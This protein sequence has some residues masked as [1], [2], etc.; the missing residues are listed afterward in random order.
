MRLR[1]RSGSELRRSLAVAVA[2]VVALAV[3]PVGSSSAQTTSCDPTK[4]VLRESNINQGL[5][6]DFLVRGKKILARF[7]L[8]RASCAP[9]SQQMLI[10]SARLT[11]TGGASQA[12]LTPKDSFGTRGAPVY[13]YDALYG[14]AGELLAPDATSHPTFV[15]D[16]SRVEA[17]ATS[18][19]SLNLGLTVGY[20]I[21]GGTPVETTFPPVSRMVSPASRPLKVLTVPM[22]LST[23]QFTDATSTAAVTGLQ[24]LAR[25]FPVADTVASVPSN[26]NGVQYSLNLASL[27]TPIM[28]NGMFCGSDAATFEDVVKKLDNFFVQHNAANPNNAVEKVQGWIDESITSPCALG[29]AKANSIE[30]WATIFRPSDPSKSKTGPTMAME[31]GHNFGAVPAHRDDAFDVTHSQFEHADVA[32]DFTFGATDTTVATTGYRDRSHS[33]ITNDYLPID[34]SALRIPISKAPDGSLLYSHWHHGNT[35]LDVNDWSLVHCKLGGP[36]TNECGSVAT[37]EQGTVAEAVA[38]IVGSTDGTPQGTSVSESFLGE[39]PATAPDPSSTLRLVQ[40][41]ASGEIIANDGVPTTE[42][43]SVHSHAGDTGHSEPTRRTFAVLFEQQGETLDRLELWEGP[44][45]AGG[46]LLFA[47]GR[48]AAPEVTSFVAVPEGVTEAECTDPFG[49][50]SEVCTTPQPRALTDERSFGA[51]AQRITFDPT[52]GRSEG[53]AVNDQY[54]AQ[55]VQFTDDDTLTPTVITPDDCSSGPDACIPGSTKTLPF[56]LFNSGDP[57]A[58]LKIGFT[59][60]QSRVGMYIGNNDY[61]QVYARMTAFDAQDEEIFSTERQLGTNVQTFVGI[62]AGAPII[63]KVVLQYFL[64]GTETP[65]FQPEEIDNLTFEAT[66][67]P[68]PESVEVP[69]ALTFTDPQSPSYNTL[70][71]AS[72]SAPADLRASFFADCGEIRQPLAV[73]LAP[74]TTS[75][76]TAVFDY[77]FDAARSCTN[78]NEATVVA[79]VN[80][81]FLQSAPAEQVVRAPEKGPEAAISSPTPSTRLLQ[82]AGISLAGTAFD[83]SDGALAG[84]AL[85]WTL[86]GPGLTG[87][88]VGVGDQVTV[89]AP[90]SGWTPGDYTATLTATDSTG[91]SDSANV[92]FQ[93]LKDAD[94]DGVTAANET[95]AGGS[96]NDP[97]DTFADG[98][99][100]GASNGADEDPCVPRVVYEAFGD[101]DPNN[102]FV[103]SSGTPVTMYVRSSMR[104][105]RKVLG[106]TVRITRI[107]GNDVTD[108]P[109]LAAIS[110]QALSPNQGIAKFDRAALTNYLFSNHLTNQY[111]T[112]TVGGSAAVEG[113]SFEATDAPLVRDR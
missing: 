89:P 106:P 17:S 74:T 39:A 42:G 19:F 107:S 27:L 33:L 12:V 67:I 9:S 3:L 88:E 61:Q 109:Q 98:D 81:G 100:D 111:V 102:L 46:T 40:R 21:N 36:T 48:S 99:S 104:D 44:P 96:D 78:G 58:D 18:A 108:V 57:Q 53:E 30:S 60:P 91:R 45:D 32:S 8:S 41:D 69:A 1:G 14:S 110:W 68:A 20:S 35:L 25:V 63:S 38:I 90:S 80:D 4:P 26:S 92:T 113:W 50:P 86:S 112:L 77:R 51:A 87:V 105:L 49:N 94:N 7:Y 37:V 54:V 52:E 29:M 70:L 55:G 59:G 83:Q 75:N 73:G 72:D 28:Q 5:P 16:A 76:G 66:P 11:M 95:C 64:N 62:D 101:F 84:E 93:I 71:T 31:I 15:I 97:F 22:G 43:V 79:I 103:P 23:S 56:A 34:L 10:T 2:G 65:G 85:R 47:R 82:H 6:Y 13:A 24:D